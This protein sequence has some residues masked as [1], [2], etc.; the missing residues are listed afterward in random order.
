MSHVTTGSSGKDKRLR[1]HA[2]IEEWAR[3]KGGVT[4]DTTAEILD[5]EKYNCRTD[6]PEC[7]KQFALISS[8]DINQATDSTMLILKSIYLMQSNCSALNDLLDFYDLK[9]KNKNYCT[10]DEF[11]ATDIYQI[12]NLVLYLGLP[13]FL[14]L[15][16]NSSESLHSLQIIQLDQMGKTAPVG[17]YIKD[18]LTMDK[19]KLYWQDGQVPLSGNSMVFGSG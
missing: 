14:T 19:S 6:D 11:T 7:V 1:D 9:F 13:E 17:N 18:E 16:T 10:M 3:L 4:T 5:T 15:G 8:I 12:V 2:S